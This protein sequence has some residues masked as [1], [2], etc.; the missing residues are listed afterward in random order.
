MYNDCYGGYSFSKAAV[1]RYLELYGFVYR[2]FYLTRIDRTDEGMIEVVKQLG[3]E[4]NGDYANIKIRKFPL[5]YKDFI[6]VGEYDGYESVWVDF[7]KYKLA[8]IYDVLN[9]AEN[10][11]KLGCIHAIMEE[12]EEELLELLAEINN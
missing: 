8:S 12:S 9:D 2:P 1:Q 10:N 4:A 3:A 6:A 7:N 5:K 11:D